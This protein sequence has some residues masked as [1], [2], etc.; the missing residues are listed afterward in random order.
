MRPLNQAYI[1]VLLF[2]IMAP[3]QA[4][5]LKSYQW[6]KRV[7]VI[8]SPQPD[9]LLF[10]RQLAILEKDPSG[11]EERHLVVIQVVG[12]EQWELRQHLGVTVDEFATVLV[13][14]DGGVKLRSRHPVER[15]KLYG[16][17]DSMPM[18]Q[19]EMKAQKKQE[20]Q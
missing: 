12:R 15:Q 13:G 2:L 5:P 16:R 17:I 1:G 20:T 7:L 10:Q 18:R 6:T 19:R 14:K 9:S 4:D 11:L 3:S 8:F